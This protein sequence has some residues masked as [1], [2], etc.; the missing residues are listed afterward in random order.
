MAHA[1]WYEPLLTFLAEQPPGTLSVIL[2]LTELEALAVQPL[3]ASAMTR[4][5]WRNR[6]NGAMGARLAARGWRVGPFGRGP[7][8]MITFIRLPSDTS[9]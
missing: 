1:R 5:Y 7:T 8:S 3:P 6:K 2:T 4:S 9:G